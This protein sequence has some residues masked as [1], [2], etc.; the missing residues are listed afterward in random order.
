MREIPLFP[1]PLVLNP[2]GEL[3]LRIFEPRYL[4]MVRDC[5]RHQSGFGICAVMPTP[6]SDQRGICSLG[7]EA[8]IADF[9]TLPDG[10]LG[11][12]VVGLERFRI[13][14]L[15]ARDNGLSIA[16]IED[17]PREPKLVVP[18][19]YGLLAE[20]VAGVMGGNKSQPLGRDQLDNASWIGF[21]L[22][23]VLP[24]ELPERQQLI[25]ITDP[26]ERLRL[27][28]EWLPRFQRSEDEDEEA[29]S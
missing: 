2:G 3:P 25:E 20:I 22:A 26:G 21:R 27:L 29:G 7:T 5:A 9:N 23:E 14:K 12:E 17:I 24:L 11:I 6:G 8:K 16:L 18:A 28:A 10:L 19:E 1:L 15:H 13:Q 4:D